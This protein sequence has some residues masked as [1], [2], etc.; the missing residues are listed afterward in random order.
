MYEYQI[1]MLPGCYVG[2]KNVQQ[3]KVSK[4]VQYRSCEN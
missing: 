1:G 4:N 3:R 2:L